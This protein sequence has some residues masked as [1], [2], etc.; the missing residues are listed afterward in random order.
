[1][2]ILSGNNIRLSFYNYSGDSIQ[3]AFTY[4]LPYTRVAEDYAVSDTLIT[5]DSTTVQV[6]P[7]YNDPGKM[8]RFLF[9]ENYR[10]EWAAPAKLPVI[11]L[12]EFR[13]RFK[14]LATGR[15]YAITIAT[16]SR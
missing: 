1:M 13:G 14:A 15:G 3:Q 9:G 5:G 10:K 8:H 6:H 7:S 16:L 12:S 2:D 11:R 4:Q